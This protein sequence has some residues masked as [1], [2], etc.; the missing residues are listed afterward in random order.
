MSVRGRMVV[1]KSSG[2]WYQTVLRPCRPSA[3]DM[4]IGVTFGCDTKILCK[5]GKNLKSFSICSIKINVRLKFERNKR[6]IC[7]RLRAYPRVELSG[8]DPHQGDVVLQAV[9]LRTLLVFIIQSTTSLSK[10]SSMLPVCFCEP[11]F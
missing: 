4:T 10:L 2:G 3:V 7:Q 5:H 9:V 8:L 11:F 6:Y 1:G